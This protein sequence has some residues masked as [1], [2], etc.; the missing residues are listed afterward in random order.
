MK[1]DTIAVN[2]NFNKIFIFFYFFILF[3]N[4][5]LCKTSQ[6]DQ[7]LSEVLS[8]KVIT[9]KTNERIAYISRSAWGD[10]I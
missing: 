4:T 1:T 2:G 6:R 3:L 5:P 10:G 7:T 9:A 8:G